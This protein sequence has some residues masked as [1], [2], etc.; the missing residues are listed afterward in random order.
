MK[1]SR[2]TVR[3]AAGGIGHVLRKPGYVAL[4]FATGF[5]AA[6]AII[7]ALNYRVLL[8][9]LFDAP[10]SI[11]TKLKFFVDGYGA[12]LTTFGVM[13]A[14]SIVVFAFLFGVNVSLLVY[15]VRRRS[16]TAVRHSGAVGLL[17]GIVGGGCAAC[18]TSL[19]VP[20]FA[21]IGVTASASLVGLLGSVALLLASLLTVI[22]I[23]RLGYLAATARAQYP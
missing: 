1:L 11:G 21:S 22:S 7:W 10:F 8:Y 12:L 2:L 4:A 9:V 13:Q 3:V 20:L 19:L 5:L 6:G 17:L 15:V 18:G 23:Y 16:M 14:V